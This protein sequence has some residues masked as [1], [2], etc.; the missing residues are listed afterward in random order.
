MPRTANSLRPAPASQSIPIDE[1][2]LFAQRVL[3]SFGVQ[4]EEA[5]IVADSLVQADARGIPSHGLTR[6]RTYCKRLETGVVRSGV[7][8]IILKESASSLLVDGQN[9]IGISL[10]DNVMRMC[11]DRSRASGSC[12]ASVRRA[13]HF[14][15]GAC[16]TLQA[17][18]AGMVGIAMSNAPASMVPTG[19]CKPMLGTNPLSIA[20]PA[21]RHTPFVLDMA[22]S[23]VAQGKVIL[24]AKE[25][26]TTI[27]STWAVD[28]LGVATDDPVAA[29]R[30]AMKPFGGAKG[31]A[32]AFAI[33][34][35][36][37]ALSGALS[38]SRIHSYWN[39]FENPQDLGFFLGAWN[40]ESFLPLQEF[41]NRVDELLDEMKASPPAPGTD[42]VL[43]PG[44]IEHR[45]LL[46]ARAE[47]VRFS[48]AVLNDLAQLG[49]E[50]GVSFPFSPEF[51]ESKS[52][53]LVA[54]A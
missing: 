49:E 6:L 11:I 21:G 14:G 16:Y 7:E 12:F 26:R 25:G 44:E 9:G 13:N 36:C 19:G 45:K 40:I 24:A 54:S 34:I 42:E 10:A 37:S 32:I 2:T 35:L 53:K 50:C 31:Y 29:L 48:P 51:S 33:D 4:A 38:S 28:E 27:P 5:F 30:G 17:A 1:L 22:T 47:G 52:S 41:Q 43:I 18:Q 20:I 15:I 46:Y 39:D 3:Q 23:E 8:P